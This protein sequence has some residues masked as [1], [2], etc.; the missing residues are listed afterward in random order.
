M[1]G[2]TCAVVL[3]TMALRLNVKTDKDPW[4]ELG[5]EGRDDVAWSLSVPPTFEL[6]RHL[7]QHEKQQRL[8]Y[9]FR[10]ETFIVL[11]Y[12]CAFLKKLLKKK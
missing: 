9:H 4:R 11:H 1:E 6:A 12:K 7:T 8:A 10:I 5:S 3:A 2:N